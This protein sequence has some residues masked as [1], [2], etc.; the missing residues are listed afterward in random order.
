MTS[1][2]CDEKRLS[3]IA[4]IPPPLYHHPLTSD[5]IILEIIHTPEHT[6][7]DIQ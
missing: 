3:S 5:P 1:S 6:L 4:S 7:P 2:H